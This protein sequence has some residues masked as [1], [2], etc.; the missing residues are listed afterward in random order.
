MPE[1]PIIAW[2]ERRSPTLLTAVTFVL[3]LLVGLADYL[4]GYS[5]S[6]LTFY[7][8]PV[9]LAAWFVGRW[10]AA[11]ISVLSVAVW[12]AGDLAAGAIYANRFIP[13][14]NAAIALT[15]FLVVVWLLTSLR[16]QLHHLEA[17]V[18]QRTAA[19]TAEMVERERLEKEILDVSERERRR[20]GHDL[21]DGL[22][23]H[24]TGTALAGK[25]LEDRLAARAL[26]EA[27]DAGR[28]VTLVEEAI[29]LTRGLARGLSPVALEVE[30]LTDALREL[31]ARTTRQFH[32]ACEFHGGDN[33]S[34]DPHVGPAESDVAMHLYRIAQE[35][36][37]NAVRHGGARRL[38]LALDAT[39]GS[40]TLTVTDDG[41][42]L[43]AP[44]DRRP[45]GMGLRIMAH[46][47][48]IM[49]AG[50][51]VRRGTPRGTVVRCAVPHAAPGQNG[52][53]APPTP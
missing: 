52:V 53:P 4:S 40:L 50:F 15:F 1:P 10:F 6:F 36:V 37:T 20:I 32:V 33:D 21:H 11:G 5:L 3:L 25:V 28:I 7:L 29:E 38:D 51:D 8:L 23:Q 14:W 24:L 44:A 2:L 41:V 49:G 35:A 47:A 27:G 9:S 30:G 45:G 12:L 22:G 34:D 31:A 46:R 43:P 13:G 18:R 39:D 19:L 42:G 26:P 17:R 48:S 16:A